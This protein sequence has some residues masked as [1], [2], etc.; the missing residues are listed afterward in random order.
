MKQLSSAMY[1]V[2]IPWQWKIHNVFHA[3]LITRC[4]LHGTNFARPPPD[5]VDGEEAYEV[6]KIIQTPAHQGTSSTT[7][8]VITFTLSMST[9]VYLENGTDRSASFSGIEATGMET[10]TIPVYLGRCMTTAMW[11]ELK[12]GSD[13]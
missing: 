2:E 11:N 5:L 9:I 13:K 1:R 6:E 10:S 4:K 8:T 12:R 7:P 3:N